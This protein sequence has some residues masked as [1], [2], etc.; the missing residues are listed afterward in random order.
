MYASGPGVQTPRPASS[1]ALSFSTRAHVRLASNSQL[2]WEDMGEC[3][4]DACP[5]RLRPVLM[6]RKSGKHAGL[7]RKELIAPAQTN[8]LSSPPRLHEKKKLTCI[9]KSARWNPIELPASCRS[10]WTPPR[11]TDTSQHGTSHQ[12]SKLMRA[13]HKPLARAPADEARLLEHLLPPR[14]EPVGASW[15]THC[16]S[17]LLNKSC[18]DP[19]MSAPSPGNARPRAAMGC[20]A[21]LI[22]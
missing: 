11:T 6:M 21:T 2:I 4:A 22:S 17:D 3:L 19:G 13:A 20:C 14:N 5:R 12:I 18:R 15:S 10:R 8:P 9:S 7:V 16:L 1:V